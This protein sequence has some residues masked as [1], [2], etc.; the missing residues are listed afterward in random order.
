MLRKAQIK[1]RPCFSYFPRLASFQ[2]GIALSENELTTFYKISNFCLRIN[3]SHQRRKD[4]SRSSLLRWVSKALYST[5][6][7][8]KPRHLH[9]RRILVGFSSTAS[10]SPRSKRQIPIHGN[11]IRHAKNK[12][13]G[14]NHGMGKVS[15]ESTPTFFL[16]S[17]PHFLT[18]S[19]LYG[20]VSYARVGFTHHIYLNT[21]EV[22]REFLDKR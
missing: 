15:Y 17:F 19:S 1:L 12:S 22:S 13:V 8:C 11:D 6:S 21:P 18:Y 10:T 9:S 20:P 14:H 5:E 4:V 2:M 3:C 7:A 16:S